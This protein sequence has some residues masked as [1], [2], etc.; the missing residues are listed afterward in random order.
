MRHGMAER[1]ENAGAGGGERSPQFVHL[2]V[3]SA[4]SLREG[5]L[6]LK[7]ILSKAVG[8]GQPAIDISDTNNLFVAL[9]FAQKAIGEGLQPI[10][11]C[12]VSIDM[13]DQADERRGHQLVKLPA[14]VL[15]AAN[16][17]GYETLVDLVSRAYL[18]GEGHQAVHIRSSW[19]EEGGTEG[20]IALTGASG[21]PVDIA[22][23]EGNAG[24]AEKR[25]LRLRELFG[26]RLYVELQRHGSYDRRHEHRM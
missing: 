4:I 1:A 13:E 25:L 17:Q 10:I 14:V 6:P 22:I 19:L 2:R 12:Q 18:D 16:A 5:A 23:R 24:Q 20:L 15:L 7:K 8:D 21:G 3:H 26:D 9:E 11:G